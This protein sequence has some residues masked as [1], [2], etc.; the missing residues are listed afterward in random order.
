MRIIHKDIARYVVNFY[1][2]HQKRWQEKRGF[3]VTLKLIIGAQN[4]IYW[5]I[6]LLYKGV[7]R[8][9]VLLPLWKL[10][11]VTF[12]FT[13]NVKYIINYYLVSL[14]WRVRVAQWIR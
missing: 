6:S 4:H 12:S 11:K 1:P 14:D 3:R 13:I 5:R 10:E 9:V 2:H 7:T 8:Q